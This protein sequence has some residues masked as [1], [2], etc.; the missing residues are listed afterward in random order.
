MMDKELY[1]ASKD[2][3]RMCRQL[4]IAEASVPVHNMQDRIVNAKA[5]IQTTNKGSDLA[6]QYKTATNMDFSITYRAKLK[7]F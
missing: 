1:L 5:T 2:R 4:T 7:Y 6:V 3:A